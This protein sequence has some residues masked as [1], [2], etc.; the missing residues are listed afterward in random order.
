VE[1]CR[2]CSISQDEQALVTATTSTS[3]RAPRSR[4]G[5]KIPVN[6]AALGLVP[7]EH[8]SPRAA[9][10]PEPQPDHDDEGAKR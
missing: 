10:I 5:P 6:S 9:G 7:N 3:W 2:V 8:R 4:R 1:E